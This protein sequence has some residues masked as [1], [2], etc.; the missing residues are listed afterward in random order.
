M[1]NTQREIDRIKVDQP[2]L[3]ENLKTI[4][5]TD[6]LAKKILQKLNDQETEI[7]KY[8]AQIKSWNAKADQ[9]RK[10]FESYLVSLSLQ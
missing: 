7:E 8:E 2:R 1:Q 10:D 9:Q 6:P 4:P 3:R 5:Q